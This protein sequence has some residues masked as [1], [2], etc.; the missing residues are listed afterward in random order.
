MALSYV[1]ISHKRDIEVGWV[2][3]MLFITTNKKKKKEKKKEALMTSRCK[4]CNIKTK[5]EQQKWPPDDVTIQSPRSS[6]LQSLRA[7]RDA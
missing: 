5:E 1:R 2:M 6:R 3:Q 7:I 4:D